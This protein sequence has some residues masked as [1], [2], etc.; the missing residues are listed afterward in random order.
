MTKW[1]YDKTDRNTL[2]VTRYV[3]GKPPVVVGETETNL[4]NALVE[5]AT[6]L[7]PGDIVITPEGSNLVLS[8]QGWLEN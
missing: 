4:N 1:V 2:Q 7:E 6:E 5:I 3:E 8:R